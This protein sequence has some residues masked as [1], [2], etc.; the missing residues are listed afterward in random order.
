MLEN[1]DK[2]RIEDLGEFGLIHH[3]TADLQY[4]HTHLGVGDDAALIDQDDHYT[5]VSKDLLTEGVHFNLM[6]APLKHLG[7]KAI[8]V[9]LSDIYAMNGT[10]RQVMVGLALSSKF[11]L[12]AVE[13]LYAGIRLACERY[14]VD[15]IGGDT[16]SSY[17]GLTLS[18]TA[19][20]E[21]KKDRVTCRHTSKPNDF[22]VVTGDLGAAYMGLQVLEREKQVFKDN[23]EVQ[24]D[25]SGYDYILERQLKPE[26]RK[27]A[28]DMLADLDLVPTSMIDISDGLASEAIHLARSAGLGVHV[29]DERLPFDPST[30]QAVEDFNLE[31]T[32]CALNGG[33]DYE[34]LFTVDPG[35]FDKIKGHPQFTVIG[36]MT[37]EQGLYYLV[38]KNAGAHP[39]KAQGWDAL[40]NKEREMKSED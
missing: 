12:E 25:L 6:Y 8:T 27:D 29:Y 13:E 9:N 37:D 2:G 38:D 11:T 22:L 20:G 32:L 7:Y 21:V 19:I 16:T 24:P 1:K 5:V 28:V 40:L 30:L 36:H 31:A 10:P 17:S 18:I 35:D 39:L 33:E 34:L 3:L 4:Q 14:G 26:A 23:P 15:L